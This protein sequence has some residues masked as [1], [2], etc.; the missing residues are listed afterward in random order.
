MLEGRVLAKVKDF[1]DIKNENKYPRFIDGMESS[2][3]QVIEVTKY[4]HNRDGFHVYRGSNGYLYREEWLDFD[5]APD[6]QTLDIMSEFVDIMDKS[7]IIDLIG[8]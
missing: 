6:Q 5:F 7:D 8:R 2:C 1:K 4:H 3:G